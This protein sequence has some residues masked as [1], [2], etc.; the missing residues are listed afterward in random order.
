M[1]KIRQPTN[2]AIHPLTHYSHQPSDAALRQRSKWQDGRQATAVQLP[3]QQ[4]FETTTTE[5]KLLI[6]SNRSNIPRNIEHLLFVIVVVVVSSQTAISRPRKNFFALQPSVCLSSLLFCSPFGNLTPLR[7]NQPFSLPGMS[8]DLS[9][10]GTFSFRV[11]SGK[12]A[13]G[14]RD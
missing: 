8:P 7:S 3:L 6:K 14:P 5:L 10:C 13:I 1:N 11:W 2:E 9:L 12:L 4:R